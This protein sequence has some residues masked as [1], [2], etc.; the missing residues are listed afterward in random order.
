[1]SQ[2]TKLQA[3]LQ[4][5]PADFTWHELTAVLQ[6]LGFAESSE[7]GGSYRTFTNAHGHK[8]FLHKPHPGNVV[9][10]YALR[11]VVEKLKELGLF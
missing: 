3:R 7:K 4:S 1:M 5:I 11:A 2:F 8:I 9:R 10:R 6:G